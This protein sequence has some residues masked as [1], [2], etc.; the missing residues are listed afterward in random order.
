VTPVELELW[1]RQPNRLHD[2]VRYRRADDS[3]RL[4]RLA[5]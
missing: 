1:E 2:R 3:W 5:P 4:E